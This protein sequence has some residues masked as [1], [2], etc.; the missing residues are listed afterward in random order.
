M[1]WDI[2][3]KY[4]KK[5]IRKYRKWVLPAI[6]AIVALCLD[7]HTAL[8]EITAVYAAIVYADYLGYTLLSTKRR[9][10]IKKLKD[11]TQVI[12]QREQEIVDNG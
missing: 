4:L 6:A 12:K 5:T 3:M 9:K 2:Y 1:V 11:A 10:A 7:W 8:L